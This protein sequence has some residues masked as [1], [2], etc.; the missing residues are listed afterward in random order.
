MLLDP[1][2]SVI[3][4]LV[5]KNTSFCLEASELLNPL[6]QSERSGFVDSRQL[7]IIMETCVQASFRNVRCIDSSSILRPG[8]TAAGT[9]DQ[10]MV[11]GL[12]WHK[13]GDLMVSTL[14]SM[15]VPGSGVLLY[16]RCMLTDLSCRVLAGM[17]S[18]QP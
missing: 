9:P 17:A 1:T 3:N 13:P 16:S 2:C 14:I 4:K 6:C 8:H 7:N 10:S 12:P 11:R 15:T 18:Q 5:I